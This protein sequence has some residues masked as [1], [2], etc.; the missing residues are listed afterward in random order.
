MEDLINL[1]YN[2]DSKSIQRYVQLAMGLGISLIEILQEL[3]I[4]P[5]KLKQFLE[6][7]KLLMDQ[8]MREKCTQETQK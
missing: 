8:T 6:S 5:M 4:P 3:V 2:E 7:T 1:L